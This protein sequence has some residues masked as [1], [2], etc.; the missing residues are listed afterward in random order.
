[1][2]V[3]ERGDQ[4]ERVVDQ[5]DLPADLHRDGQRQGDPCHDRSCPPQ[6]PEC[7][8]GDG[9][10]DPDAGQDGRRDGQAA[11]E[12]TVAEAQTETGG[13][14]DGDG[15]GHR[16][17]QKA[18]H[19]PDPAHRAGQEEFRGLVTAQTQHRHDPVQGKRIHRQFVDDEFEED[20]RGIV[21]SCP[22]G[23]EVQSSALTERR[24]GAVPAQPD[25]RADE[26]GS[27]DPGQGRAPVQ[28]PGQAEWPAQAVGCL[29]GAGVWRHEAGAEV[30]AGRQ[31][32]R[33]ADQ[34][35]GECRDQEVICTAT[36]ASAAKIMVAAPRCW[37][38]PPTR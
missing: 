3:R 30:A 14:Q 16:E 22:S 28:P 20:L 27:R 34:S 10:H 33:G 8:R 35:R 21:G 11:G 12:V 25:R 1:M 13:D 23:P 2:D 24:D 17:Q 38:T 9:D 32:V 6:Q 15:H 5:A 26:G 29:G 18:G 37:A 4:E 31:C 19:P 7:R 36:A